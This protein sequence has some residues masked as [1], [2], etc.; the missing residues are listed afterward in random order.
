MHHPKAGSKTMWNV[1]IETESE[2]T[3]AAAEAAVNALEGFHPVAYRGDFGGLAVTISLEAESAKHGAIVADALFAAASL[4][5]RTLRVMTADDYDA[6]GDWQ[7]LL[8]VSDAAEQLGVTR[9]AHP[10]A[11]QRRKPAGAAGR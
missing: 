10:V 4:E 2:L 3:E 8:S 5:V 9:Q 11:D 1:S 7:E 6:G